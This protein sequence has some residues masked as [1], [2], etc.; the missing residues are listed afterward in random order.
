MLPLN[1]KGKLSFTTFTWSLKPMLSWMNL[2]GFP[3][4]LEFSHN[5]F[6]NRFWLIFSFGILLFICNTANITI[7]TVNYTTFFYDAE[8]VL[9]RKEKKF[10]STVLWSWYADLFQQFLFNVAT[11]FSLITGLL[12]NW[13][14]LSQALSMIERQNIY[15]EETYQKFRHI[16]N[17]GL[18]CIILIT[19]Y[20]SNY[21]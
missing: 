17:W 11:Y 14:S 19:G 9:Y 4:K 10:S 18:I 21:N 7:I 3:L 2:I 15:K 12:L 8:N 13:Q 1:E 16:C 6:Q 20:E 5:S